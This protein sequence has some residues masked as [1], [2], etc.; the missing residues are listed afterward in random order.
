MEYLPKILDRSESDALVARIRQHFAEYG[1][2]PW[3]LEITRTATFIGLAGLSIARFQAHFTPCVEI[4]W[5]LARSYWGYGY[6]TE[7]ARAAL[8]YGFTRLDLHEIVAFTTPA[9]LRSRAVMERLGLVY[10]PDDDF[11]HPALAP[12]HPLR[13][14]VLY[15]SV[16]RD[17]ELQAV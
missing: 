15:R 12:D 13:R 3:A 9:N 10:D 5:R 16:R 4:G 7:A 14:H 2:A 6:A 8:Q 11:D 1:F 17:V